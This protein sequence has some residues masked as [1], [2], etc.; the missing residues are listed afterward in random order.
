MRGRGTARPRARGRRSRGACRSP[1]RAPAEAE[2]LRR[3]RRG[4]E[5]A[6]DARPGRGGGGEENMGSSWAFRPVA[7]VADVRASA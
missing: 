6:G 1:R 2:G 4:L 3:V 7:T 5:R